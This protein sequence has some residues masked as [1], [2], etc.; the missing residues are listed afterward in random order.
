MK[1]IITLIFVLVGFISI[2]N[3]VYSYSENCLE[4]NNQIDI[5]LSKLN[6]CK[7][8]C[9]MEKLTWLRDRS[10]NCEIDVCYDKKNDRE[11]AKNTYEACELALDQQADNEQSNE[12][13]N[14]GVI[15]QDGTCC[16]AWNKAYNNKTECCIWTVVP[17]SENPGREACITNTVWNMWINM[18]SNCLI[19]WQ[20]NYN[21]YKTVWI[22]KSDPNPSVSTFVQDVVLWVTMFI[23]TVITVVLIVSWILYILA[24]ILWRSNLAD[25]AKKW[26]FNSI[27]WLLL[28]SWSYAVVR[29]IQFVATGGS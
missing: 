3:C 13:C 15:L 2:N 14:W 8:Q 16:P 10:V 9:E 23:G 21:I 20:C 24:A 7:E 11:N 26:I 19:N 17:D 29:L 18:D 1:K 5:C 27:L 4:E 28:V 12:N 25:M 22:R 6:A